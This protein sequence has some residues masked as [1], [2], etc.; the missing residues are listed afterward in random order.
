MANIKK[1]S[2][3]IG[4]IKRGNN[5]TENPMEIKEEI[6]NYFETLYSSGK[7]LRPQLEGVAFPI[8]SNE[9]RIWLERDFE[10]D[11][12]FSA[13]TD[14]G[15]DKASGPDGFNFS[16][17]Q[18]A[19]AFIKKDFY[20]MLSKFHLRGRLNKEVNATF[21][22][23]IPKAPNPVDVKDFRPIS[24]VG[25]VYKLLSKILANRMRK[26]LPSLISPM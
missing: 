4:K 8:I 7:F 9:S 2:N 18:A 22:T 1:R 6:A 10:E 21:F 5:F 12:N 23:L 13:M 14:C 20:E 11:E 24:L 17:M 15:G 3:F 16:F 26:V 19:W 25:C